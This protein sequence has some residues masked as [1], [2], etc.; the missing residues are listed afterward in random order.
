MATELQKFCEPPVVNEQQHWL[1]FFKEGEQLNDDSGLAD[2]MTTEEMRQAMN[3]LK[4]FSEKDKDY[5]AYQARQNFFREQLSRQHELDEKR[6]TKNEAIQREQVAL[7][8]K[9]DA[10]AEIERL[11][12]LLA[13]NKLN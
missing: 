1:R 13:K 3:T 7:K 8:D 2:W 4:Q 12:A 10:L 5:H 6:Q 9:A 11:K